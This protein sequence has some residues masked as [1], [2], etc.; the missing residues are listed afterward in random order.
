[1]KFLQNPRASSIRVGAHEFMSMESRSSCGESSRIS[2]RSDMSF[3]SSL[4]DS[5]VEGT[6][7]FM[8]LGA[9]PREE[10]SMPVKG[11]SSFLQDTTLAATRT[12]ME[13]CEEATTEDCE[14]T[15]EPSQKQQNQH[16][17]FIHKV[18]FVPTC[19]SMFKH[20]KLEE[21][22]KNTPSFSHI[23]RWV[24]MVTVA[25]LLLFCVAALLTFVALLVENN[26]STSSQN[27][28]VGI[29]ASYYESRFA[30]TP[31]PSLDS[32]QKSSALSSSSPTPSPSLPPA[33][34][35]QYAWLRSKGPH[36]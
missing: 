13:D 7:N 12:T 28:Q 8:V 6:N 35:Q 14:A 2:S 27:D 16:R 1:M 20:R 32:S 18:S 3:I 23:P 22:T 17:G 10:P 15:R 26:Q 29:P 31:S 4:G 5:M 9:E 19:F 24:G 34:L 21:E 30:P 33:S 25:S 36:N 11:L